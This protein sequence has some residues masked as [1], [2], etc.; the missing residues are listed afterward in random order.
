MIVASSLF[1]LLLQLGESF[2]DKPEIDL[3]QLR[4]CCDRT[5]L[6]FYDYRIGGHGSLHVFFS[7][8]YLSDQSLELGNMY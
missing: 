2:S 4:F 8:H 5:Q 3:A 6:A 7:R 1:V